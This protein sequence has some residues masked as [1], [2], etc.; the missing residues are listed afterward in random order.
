MFPR[1]FHLP[2]ALRFT[3]LAGASS[4]AAAFAAPPVPGPDISPFLVGNNVWYH[5]PSPVVWDLTREAGVRLLRIGGTGYDR[6]LPDDA[7]LI[8]RVKQIR[9]IGAEPLLQVSQYAGP[10]RAAEVKKWGQADVC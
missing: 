10:A 1:F 9:A 7:T 3:L 2:F 6:R 8:A 5:T 4:Y